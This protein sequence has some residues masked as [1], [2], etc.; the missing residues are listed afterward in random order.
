MGLRGMSGLSRTAVPRPPRRP[1]VFDPSVIPTVD[2]AATGRKIF[3]VAEANRALPYIQ[4]VVTDIA[5]VYAQVIELRR[6]LDGLDDGKARKITAAEYEADMDRLGD[7]VDEL[8][9]VG[10][11]LRDFE[12]GRVDF[13]ALYEDRDVM[14]AWQ[15]GETSV[16]AWRE[17]DAAADELHPVDAQ[18]A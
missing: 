2:S 7:L 15:I 6:E 18:L 11:E 9:A 4:R 1:D 13:P 12:N 17:L 3:T 14:L 5:A 8:H 10:V 16:A